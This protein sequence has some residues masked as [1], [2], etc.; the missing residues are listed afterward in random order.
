MA[1]SYLVVCALRLVR[2]RE[3]ATGWVLLGS[4]AMVA[5]GKLPISREGGP[6][7]QLGGH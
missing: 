1:A 2:A 6:D 3:W 4:N 7:L 5:S